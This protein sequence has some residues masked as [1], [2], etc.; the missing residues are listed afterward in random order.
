MCQSYSY[1]GYVVDPRH[2]ATSADMTAFADKLDNEN[3]AACI[4]YANRGS[5]ASVLVP[6]LGKEVTLYRLR[7]G[8]ERFL[9]T[10]IN[11]PAGSAKAQSAIPI[12]WDTVGT[13]NGAPVPDQ[14]NHLPM[15]ANVLFFDGHVELGHYPQ[16]AG[17]V[18]W[19]L[20]KEAA[21]DDRPAF[22]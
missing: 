19:M 14:Y 1:W 3:C 12:M 20:T 4:T 17:S 18:M 15:S 5:D 2:V 11:I 16:S 6:S 7:E 10:D 13:D 8:I 21:I 9:I 22:P